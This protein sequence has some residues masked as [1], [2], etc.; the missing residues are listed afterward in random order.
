MK[1]LHFFQDN[2]IRKASRT[3]TELAEYSQPVAYEI[4]DS[5]PM[6]SIGKIDTLELKRQA[7]SNLFQS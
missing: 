6:T 3:Q 4:V 1:I 5:F 2:T 7:E